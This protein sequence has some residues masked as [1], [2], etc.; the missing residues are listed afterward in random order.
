L[1]E[2]AP[3]LRRWTAP[4]PDWEPSDGGS[5]GWERDV[6][7]LRLD[8]PDG[9]V[10]IDPLIV[11]GDPDLWAALNPSGQQV[12]VVVTLHW[13]VRSAAELAERYGARVWASEHVAGRLGDVVTDVFEDGDRLP[14]GIVGLD[15]VP[16]SNHETEGLVEE[17]TLWL[18][19][20]RVIV[21]GD[22]LVGAADGLRIWWSD[23]EDP[24]WESRVLPFVRRLAELPVEMVLPAH[25]EPVTRDGRAELERALEA[26]A[27]AR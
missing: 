11:G 4:H 2:I 24:L 15:P 8:S 12:T 21:V 16:V 27:W 22:L 6:A 13:H 3:G 23:R 1:E 26:P 7:C 14:G 19:E 18:P 20:Q 25:G 17:A 5:G 10:L 9:V